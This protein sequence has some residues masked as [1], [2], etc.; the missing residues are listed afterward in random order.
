MKTS[1]AW[2][3]G[4]AAGLASR[5]RL[6]SA[7]K[8]GVSRTSLKPLRVI[9]T[10]CE[11]CPAGCG[12]NAYLNGERLV[13]LLGNP[14]HPN[15]KGGICAKGIAGLNLVND[16]ERL[17]YPLKRRGPRGDGQWTKITWDEVY[18]TLATRVKELIRRD[19]ISEFVIDK[20]HDDPLLDRFITAI[21]VTHV[22]DRPA[23]KNFN[24]STAF[25]SMTGFPSLV[26]DVGRS[27]FVLNF[28]ANP[29]AN[30]DQFVG[31]ASRLIHAQVESGA[32]LI[33]FD[34]RMSETA[35]KSDAWY[36]IK[37]GTD[38]IVALAMAKVIVAKGLANSDF[39]D[40]KTNYSLAMIKNHLSHYTPEKAAKV[41]GVR[42]TDIQNLAVDFARQRPSLALI[43]GGVSDHKNGTQSV[44]S[45]ALLN[46][47]VGNLEEEGGLFYPR[48]PSSL[49]PKKVD[50]NSWLNSASNIKGITEL[51]EAKRRINTYF[52]YLSNPAYADPDCD[53]TAGLLKDEKTVPFLVVMDTHLTE[54]ARM[55]DMVLPAATYLEGWGVSSAASLD[56][57]PVLNLR[58][59][60]V[61]M[62]SAAKALRSPTFD[63]GKLLEPKFQPKGQAEEVGN[64][65]LELARRMRGNTAKNLPYKNTYDYITSV[66]SSI[67]GL[68]ME[69]GLNNLKSKGLW[70]DK[71]SKS[72]RYRY[73]SKKELPALHQKVEI[74]SNAL[75][76]NGHSPLPEYEPLTTPEKRKDEFILT[77]FKS[78]L[79]AKG[80]ANSKWAR[81]I[82][83]EN[84]LW[85]N[86]D[87]AQKLGI[88]NGDRIR[89]TS[90]VGS[91]ISRVLTTQRIHPESVALA[92]GFGHSEV[93]NVA[94]AKR[95]RSDD[96][97]TNLIW[98]DKKGNGVN[99]NKIIVRK[100]DPIGGGLG[101]KDTRIRIEKI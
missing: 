27:R 78:N 48:F 98:W 53:S 68:K 46:W 36:P 92:E 54:T 62:I 33:T 82:L 56:E 57:V 86:K 11:Q 51:K 3:A 26:E 21:G 17:L 40:R 25:T 58:Q 38:G 16:P 89:V 88:K 7:R 66:I 47:L 28:G 5:Q 99:P 18:S 37:A 101:L 23:M 50:L 79:W 73:S 70:I 63:V 64:V 69:G 96:P 9:P 75:K 44:R 74:Y 31:I 14:D 60:V 6:A 43:G 41:S 100:E 10:T 15:N 30:H 49:Q 93:G 97:D 42:A 81:E 95:F 19:K 8:A 39:I 20:G 4:T 22:I 87:V 80:T 61:S 35:A 84:R 52:A 67:P 13:Q 45:V 55:A 94:K 29:Y 71:A 59:P 32:R 85:I 91:L 12:I 90:S 76:Q 1:I 24:R 83:H 72:A 65:C 34:V 77:T 2:F